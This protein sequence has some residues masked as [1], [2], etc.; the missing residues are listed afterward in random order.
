MYCYIDSEFSVILY[1]FPFHLV[2]SKTS[3]SFHT[4]L[5]NLNIEQN[6]GFKINPSLAG[7]LST[8]KLVLNCQ[9]HTIRS[10]TY[11]RYL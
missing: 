1:N 10:I 4:L 8:G 7:I 6:V 2:K 5:M 3:P 9:E 11:V